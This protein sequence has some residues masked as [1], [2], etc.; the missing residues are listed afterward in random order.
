MISVSIDSLLKGIGCNMAVNAPVKF[1]PEECLVALSNR[2]LK[3]FKALMLMSSAVNT[4]KDLFHP[5]M[6][7]KCLQNSEADLN[8]VGAMLKKTKD[9]RFSKVI[10]FCRNSRQKPV[11]P[12][13]TLS[14]AARTGQSLFDS[15][16]EAFGIKITELPYVDEKKITSLGRLLRGN[17][18][19]QNRI[20][21]GCNW[22]ADIVSCMSLGF[23][24]PSAIKKRLNCSYET[25]HRVFND[26]I[27]FQQC[28]VGAKG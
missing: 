13:R 12:S 19:F 17:I 6:L 26:Y 9:R 5:E 8:I 16:F 25:A 20:L 2:V 22:R 21:F 14:L 23:D 15:D 11:Q 4:Y 7:L 18:Y 28:K 10:E 27:L 3:D 1:F 24:N